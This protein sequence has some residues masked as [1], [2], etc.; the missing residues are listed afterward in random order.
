M[1]RNDADFRASVHFASG[2]ERCYT[3]EEISGERFFPGWVFD[4]GDEFVQ[5][6]LAGLRDAGLD[7]EITQYSFCTNGSHYAG[8]AG[9]RTI[10]FGPSRENLAHTID[11]YIEIDQLLKSVEGYYG[12]LGAVL[13]RG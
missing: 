12:I 6:A 11:E 8:E 5:A 2:A 9:I 4:T 1:K 7:P 10:G 3:G 13:R